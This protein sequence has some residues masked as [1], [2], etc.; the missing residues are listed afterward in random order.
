MLDAADVLVDG[1]PVVRLLA[2]EGSLVVLRVGIAHVVPA[3]AGEGVHGV[4]LATGRRTALRAGALHELL[5]GSQGLA[6]SQ[7]DVFRQ[8]DGQVLFGN[9]HDAAFGAVDRGDGVAPI[10]LAA[11]QPIAQAEFHLA[12]TAAGSFQGVDDGLLAFG[13]LAAHHAGV[14]AGL[15]Q[16][17]F[18]FHGAF[19]VDAGHDP[20][21]LVCQL[22]IQGIVLGHDD[23]D[24]GQIVLAG[25]FEVALVAAGNGHDRTG[26]VVGDHIVGHP[27]G[28]LLAVDGIDDI[29]AGE[30]TVLFVVAL[31]ALDG[32]DLRGRLDEVE[33]FLLMLGSGNQFLQALVF[34]GE[35]EEAAAEQGVSAGGEDG[36]VVFGSG[37]FGGIALLVAQQEF[38]F[39]AL[40]AADPVRLLL[41]D[42][43]GPAIQGIQVVQQ[44]LG[45]VGDLEV[46]LGQV[47][48]LHLAVAAPALA[49][50]D[51]LVRQNGLAARA[52]VH[53]VVAALDQSA[54]PELQ[55][56]VLAP[57]V[58]FGVAGH[59]HAVPVIGETHALEAL[60]LGLDIAVG[61][62]GRMA[63]A[64]DCGVFR[65]QAECVPAHG[66]QH[67]VA[68]HAVVA[69]QHVADAV[70][71]RVAHMDVARRIGEHLEHVLLRL[72]GIL[73]GLVQARLVPRL[74]EAR[75]YFMRIIFFHLVPSRTSFDLHA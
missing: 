6:C 48:L 17:A 44:L 30:C 72:V 60:L 67:V 10:A 68:A 75:L 53:G 1:Q 18:G 13:M 31:G 16:T 59:D 54:L 74:L 4:G 21:L 65:R 3:G 37:V 56:E 73:A 15:D 19:P 5:V 69:R 66:M 64:L 27:D 47:A 55:E 50:D 42:A 63:L 70:I 45:V 29:A 35:H 36:D 71:A 33:H 32:G 22:A 43:V 39:G 61:P 11:D 46:P 57:A 7:V 9:G 12:T 2:V 51:L 23:G 20:V 24:D 38:H 8:A 41:L 14:G 58:V 52:P 34:G 28:H 25:E 49:F 26:T 62:L 40:G